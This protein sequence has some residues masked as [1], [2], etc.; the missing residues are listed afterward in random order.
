VKRLLLPLKLRVA[1]HLRVPSASEPHRQTAEHRRSPHTFAMDLSDPSPMVNGAL[2]R[3]FHH[4]KV[5]TVLKI[6][7]RDGGNIIG[8]LPDGTPVTV[9][10][11]AAC[12]VDARRRRERGRDPP[13]FHSVLCS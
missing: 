11:T 8:Q 13:F 9:R 7:N 6:L 3:R 10:F 4:Q 1:E 12:R 2:M 5:K